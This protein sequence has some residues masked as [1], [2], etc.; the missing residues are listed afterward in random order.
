MGLYL[1][2]KKINVKFHL[3]MLIKDFGNMHRVSRYS[4]YSYSTVYKNITKLTQ[5]KLIITNKEGREIIIN[6]TDKGNKLYNHLLQI[7][8]I[9]LNNGGKNNEN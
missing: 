7:N 8:E 2:I 1:E 5:E 6:L 4:R 3:L 9:L